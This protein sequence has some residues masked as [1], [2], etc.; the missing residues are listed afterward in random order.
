MA[1]NTG[2]LTYNNGF[3]QT[4]YVYFAPT[5]TIATTQEPLATYYCF[6]SRVQ[7]WSNDELPPAPTEDIKYINQVFKNMFV[8]KKNCKQ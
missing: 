3:Y 6:L 7:S 2:I 8:A 1:A 5:S 4:K